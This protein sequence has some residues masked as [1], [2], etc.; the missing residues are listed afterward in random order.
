MNKVSNI[1]NRHVVLI[2]SFIIYILSYVLLNSRGPLVD[3]DTIEYVGFAKA[4]SEGSFPTSPYYQPGVG[5]L[6][7][8]FKNLFFTDY[9]TAFR[10]LNFT[11]G[12]GLVLVLQRLFKLAFN[13]QKYAVSFIAAMPVIVYLSSLL[14]A[15]IVFNV[16]AFSSLLFLVRATDGQDNRNN[17]WI[18]SILAASSIF[19]KYN[20]L[21]VCVTGIVFI[22]LRG[23]IK[24]QFFKS[25]F[26]YGVIYS[27]FPIGFVIFWRIFNGNLAMVQ[28]NQWI[29]P[30]TFECIIMYL[31]QNWIS[32][33][34]CS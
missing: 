27:M 23:L 10:I 31:K 33:Y 7:F 13:T 15:D 22:G 9:L 24:K 4:I 21:A 1:I 20:G 14:Y 34:H 25:I 12:F 29:E 3:N 16:F 30:V 8:I 2:L 5:L 28:F 18:A 32:S 17:I 11:A 19:M 26:S 6:I